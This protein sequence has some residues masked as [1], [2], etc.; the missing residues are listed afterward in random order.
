[1]STPGCWGNSAGAPK[2]IGTVLG[3]LWA[4]PGG[5]GLIVNAGGVYL[6]FLPFLL[7]LS[8]LW[9]SFVGAPQ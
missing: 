2:V 9:I 1:M 6:S 3:L 4:L 8:L 5:Y 7:G